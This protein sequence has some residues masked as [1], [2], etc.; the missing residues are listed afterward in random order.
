MPLPVPPPWATYSYTAFTLNV[1]DSLTSK[2]DYDLVVVDD[3]SLEPRVSHTFSSIDDAIKYFSIVL[4]PLHCCT[5]LEM[6]DNTFIK[7]LEDAPN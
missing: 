7:L 3:S 4:Y 5:D 1:E 2:G 6:V